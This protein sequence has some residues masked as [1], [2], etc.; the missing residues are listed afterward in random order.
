MHTVPPV[1]IGSMS[2]RRRSGG[3]AVGG[4]VALPLLATYFG[5]S[6]LGW[7]AAAVALVVAAPRLAAGDLGA[8]EPVLAVHLLALGFLPLAV[9]GA[10]FHL[11]PVMLRN[12][13]RSER[14]LMASLPLLTFGAWLVAPG[15]AFE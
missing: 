3:R 7:L 4:P 13:L 11:L 15:V 14:R 1:T 12:S 9:S 2:T 8:A 10:T 5:I 6:L